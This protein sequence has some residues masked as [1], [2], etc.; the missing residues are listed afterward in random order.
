MRKMP[1][2]LAMTLFVGLAIPP[3]VSAGVYNTAEPPLWPMPASLQDFQYRLGEL[4]GIA[5][6]MPRNPSEKQETLRERYLR[7]VAELEAKER[8]DG[9]SVEDRVNLGG[10][11]IRLM[12][13]EE[14]VRVLTPAEA[15]EPG[16]FMVLGNLATASQGAGRLERATTYLQQALAAWPRV[17]FA[18]SPAQ[19]YF[20][21][22]VERYQLRLLQLRQQ[23]ARL[24]PGRPAETVDALF[25]RVRF[26]G[27]SG[28][29][30]P[31]VIALDQV[32]ELPAE[33]VEVVEQLVFWL[34]FDDR[35]YW[36]LA[37]LLNAA[38][39]PDSAL[40]L[41]KDLSYG[42]RFNAPEFMEHRR[43]LLEQEE[44]IKLF[45]PPT[46]SP[47]TVTME[48]LFGVV[49]PRGVGL[50]P[51]AGAL[52]Q[53]AAWVNVVRFLEGRGNADSPLTGK[54]QDDSQLNGS[55]PPP[56]KAPPAIWQPDVRH[57]VVSFLAGVAVTMFLVLQVRA[58][59]A[60]SKSAGG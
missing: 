56:G 47:T 15:Q 12:K 35:L 19:L 54:G 3:K 57:L 36:L 37:E 8:T 38:G 29:Y 23:E 41:M 13:Y 4:R 27:A 14:A 39:K 28:K 6:E 20:Y 49:Q 32:D 33:C 46:G 10:Y 22:T 30:E 52:S 42:R 43:I 7:R 58:S 48:Q 53:E 18:F 17:H 21:R 24:Q 59:R 51:G 5:V 55:G 45:T 31:G 60:R 16:N 11:L 25:G 1:I 50:A 34:P 40:I 9:L 2:A 26:V 44:A